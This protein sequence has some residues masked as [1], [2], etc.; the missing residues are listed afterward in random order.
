MLTTRDSQE[1][2]RWLLAIAL[3]MCLALF[4]CPLVLDIPLFDPDEGL[5]ASIAQEM[6]ERG[7]WVTPRLQGEPFLDKPILYFWAEALSLKLLGMDEITVRLP[8]VLFGL[9]GVATTALVAWRLF[10]RT[11]GLIAAL[12]YATTILPT[13]MAQAASHDVALVPWVNLGLLLF[14]EADR[15][16]SRRARV[17]LTLAVGVVLGL[18]C[19]TKGLVG[20]A[21]IGVAYGSAL[22][23]L[24]RLTWAACLRGVV[25]LA[26]AAGVAGAW[27][28]AM[29]LR[30]PGY[31]YYYFVE[32]H[33]LGYVTETQRHGKAAFWF[34]VPI[35]L[36]GGLPWIAYLPAMARHAWDNR[37]SLA[38]RH[39]GASV[40]LWCWLLADTLLLS[41]A[42]S[43][44]VTYVW[45]VFPAVAILAAVAWAHLLAG[46]LSP[47]ARRW[48]GTAFLGLCLGGPATLPAAML[49]VQ[50]KY[51][52][53]Y[54]PLV[55]LVGIA[56]ALSSWIPIW[57]WWRGSIRHALSAGTLSIAGQ[58][59]LV[60]AVV[61][62]PIA[63][64]SSARE[65]AAYFNEQ[66]A[67]PSRLRV[68][69]E[70]IG[71]IL[72]YLDPAL[73]RQLQPG[74]IESLASDQVAE[75]STLQPGTVLAVAE[76]RLK[77]LTPQGKLAGV[78]FEQAGQYRLYTAA[79]LEAHLR[80]LAPA[81]GPTLR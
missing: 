47:T 60:M 68:V 28:V 66:G 1:G 42:Q 5:H 11:T 34:Y 37:R 44:M 79:A 49:V 53:H 12:T 74:Q 24:R 70:R 61:L 56:V 51:H 52:L 43:K 39:D 46:E 22:L 9:L 69:D 23:L 15:A 7:D 76:R 75:S 45:P 33:L 27:Y 80:P 63:Q 21:L 57:S 78:P 17:G 35:V 73:R 40:L 18:A 19:L 67:L 38:E 16:A 55:W 6:V 14:W 30:N 25:A 36:G 2:K 50:H 32:R 54:S 81:G 10:D 48:F 72:F 71:S 58:F 8:G 29:E 4:V 59:A 3:A 62:P 20:V 64:V 13:A 65:L 26:V 77:R 31:L 41:T